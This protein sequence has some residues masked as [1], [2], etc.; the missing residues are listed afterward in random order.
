MQKRQTCPLTGAGF[1][2]F[3]CNLHFLPRATNNLLEL[4]NVIQILQQ[5]KPFLGRTSLNTD[6]TS[7]IVKPVDLLKGSIARLA[8]ELVKITNKTHEQE[9]RISLTDC[10]WG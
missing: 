3:L 7:G 2:T 8:Y 1:C 6:F 5:Y 4:T 10:I 9:I